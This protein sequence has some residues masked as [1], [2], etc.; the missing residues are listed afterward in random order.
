[1]CFD[2]TITIF[3]KKMVIDKLNQK[4]FYPAKN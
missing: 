1:M 4:V 3:L 2:K